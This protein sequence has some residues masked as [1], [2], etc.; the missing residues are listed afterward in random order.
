MSDE[1]QATPSATPV[2]RGR[3]WL[4]AALAGLLALVAALVTAGA[5]LWHSGPAQARLLQAVPGLSFEGLS[6]RATGGVFAIERLRWQGTDLTVEIDGLQWQNLSWRWRPHAGAWIG[7]TLEQP[8]ARA[9]RV[10]RQASGAAPP[11][12]ALQ[13]PE[14]LRLPLAFSAQGLK[15]GSVQLDGQELLSALGADLDLAADGGALHRISHLRL[16]RADLQ[17]T[18][19]LSLGT[20]GELPLAARLALA[21]PAGQPLALQGSLEASGPLRRL[22]LNANLR[23]EAGAELTAQATVT[24]FADWPLA[25][26]ML[27]AKDLDLSRLAPGLPETALS[28]TA[29]LG[30]VS[31]GQPLRLQLALDNAK[32][33]PW[34]AGRLPVRSAHGILQ[35]RPS[36]PERLVFDAWVVGLGRGAADGRLALSGSWEGAQLDLQLQLQAVQAAQLDTRAPRATVDGTLTLSLKGLA[37][38]GSASGTDAQALEGSV[39]LA[40]R[41]RLPAP[42]A[43]RLPPPPLTLRSDIAFVL[44]TDRSLTLELRAFEAS[45]GAA[46]AIATLNARRDAAGAWA[47]K[48][49]GKLDHV[50]LAVW[51]PS[52]GTS[53]LNG[54][55]QADLQLPQLPLL[56]TTPPEA[57]LKALRGEAELGLQRSQMAGVALSGTASVQAKSQ[58][59]V[60]EA[61]MQAASNR[62]QLS[63]KTQAGAATGGDRQVWRA[64]LQAPALAALAPLLARLPLAKGWL[65]EAGA[66]QA[67]ATATGV[68]PA[69]HSEGQ[70]QLDGLRMAQG[71]VHKA[72]LRWTFN[73]LALD[74]PIELDAEVSGL[75]QAERRIDRLHASLAG[76]LREHRL[77]LEADSPLRPPAWT[78]AVAG[79]KDTPAPGSALRLQAQGRWQPASSSATATLGAGV[80][81]GSVSTLHAGPRAAGA[82]PWLSA[83]D[84]VAS[85]T[86]DAQTRPTQ[87]VLAPGRVEVFGGALSWQQAQWLP[88]ERPGGA[89]RI[90][91]EAQLEPLKVA[92]ILARLQPEFGWRGDLVVG[93]RASVRSGA[94]FDADIT[95][96]RQGGDLGLTLAG[97]RRDL[98]LSTARVALAA[99]DG[100]WLLSQ[101]LVGKQVGVFGGS[102]KLETSAEALWP[103][104]QTPLEGGFSLQVADASIW[105]PWLPPGWRLGGEVSASLSLGGQLG[106]PT[107]TG[108]L[109]GERLLV[110]NIFEGINLQNG[111]VR[112]L[113]DRSQAVVE[114]FHFQGGDGGALDLQGRIGYADAP[115]A[116]LKLVLDKFRA[117]NRV[118]R[119]VALSGNADLGLRAGRLSVQGRLAIDEG[120]I[121]VTADEAPSLSDDVVV[122]GRT[123]AKGRPVAVVDGGEAAKRGVLASTD[124]D[125][126]LALGDALRLRGRGLD[127]LLR[128]QL[129]IT[130]TAAGKLVVRGVVNTAE[131][132]YTAYGQN[133]AIQ[134]G[135][136]SFTGDVTNPR[137][138]ILALRA[139][140]DN[141]VGVIVSGLAVDPRVRLYSDPDLPEV[142]QLTW[143]LTGQAPQGQGRD[144]SALLQR[145]AM[146]LLAGDRGASD[147]GFLQKLGIDQFGVGRTDG[148]D[149]VVTIG[150]QLSKRLSIVY[151]KGLSAAGGTWALLYRIAGRTTLRARTG[152]ENAVEVIWSWRWD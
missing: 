20:G 43:G 24:A 69:L 75:A 15:V 56:P 109:L 57:L 53:D 108:E 51:W 150:K 112:V 10:V 6:G 12:E 129:H 113:L 87:A 141:P 78:D 64:E 27:R 52:A 95:I 45:A 122:V 50:D 80:W 133:L 137:L 5:W 131:G 91:L 37:V 151:E 63:G 68:W 49:D 77:R 139:D 98:E 73:G 22:Q 16:S 134:R 8:Q 17:V 3:H 30:D 74:A 136:I 127:T 7:L 125:L 144:E 67:S 115:Q 65:P 117:L 66:L 130:T 41:G 132:T 118:D 25:A 61:Q 13:A 111:S 72:K 86:L 31:A 79:A 4:W 34:D 71:R 48:S 119:R 62:L 18:G 38:P 58:G 19:D 23:T 32:P 103:P 116:E 146:A 1:A 107:A 101:A 99:H 90:T 33:G 100:H 126:R 59:L 82:E 89:P 114:K 26:L 14:N 76:S 142:D 29:E 128:G 140:I 102:Q 120:L 9:V 42:A 28:G 149:T 21:T 92:P 83:R 110:R 85:I 145:A 138:D 96:E 97:S 94:R 104:A 47:L 44:P 93:G 70:L 35:G 135:S 60:V 148:G 88:P 55:W 152:L 124:V 143:L 121:D 105:A 81:R 11:G 147:E 39:L 54:Q 40:L 106:E 84:L 36:E 2:R 46:K 123:D